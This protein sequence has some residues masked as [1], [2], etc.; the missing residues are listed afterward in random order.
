MR[1]AA[2][3]CAV[4]RARPRRS[5]PG[6]GSRAG[7]SAPGPPGRRLTCW[8]HSGQDLV[9]IFTFLA[10]LEDMLAAAAAAAATGTPAPRLRGG[11][12]GG[13]AGQEGRASAPSG[14][15]AVER[16]PRAGN[17]ARPPALRCPLRAG[18]GLSLVPPR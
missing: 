4:L 18:G 16:P 15:G 9:A 11:R 6:A 17:G 8:S 10:L 14:G 13:E 5:G 2:L 3:C 7:G 12:E 1:C